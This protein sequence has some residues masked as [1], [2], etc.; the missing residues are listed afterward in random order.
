MLN[1]EIPEA[2]FIPVFYMG[3]EDADL[4]ELGQ[5]TIHGKKIKWDTHQTGA[6]GR[7]QIDDKL[8]RLIDEVEGQLSVEE[9]GPEII[10][11]LKTC[12]V[13][14]QTIEQATF[15]FVNALFK[16]FGLVVLLPDSASLKRLFQKTIKEELTELS[17]SKKVAETIAIFP[18]EYKVQAIGRD[19]NLFYL[20]KDLRARIEKTEN[21]FS[22]AGTNITF[23]H[24]A[25]LNEL[26]SYPERFS[27]NVI[28]RPLYQETIL[29][30][31]AFI[32]GG[33]E[34]A[35]W[36]ELKSTFEEA[37]ILFP[38]LL[39]R[40]SFMVID[41][42]TE[43]KLA[44]LN[45]NP[46]DFFQEQSKI[47][48]HF[49]TKRSSETLSLASEKEG[50]T[51]IYRQIANISSAVDPTLQK[52]V[53]ALSAQALNRLHLLEKKLLKVE[54]RKFETEEQQISKIK[55]ALFP[56][57]TL[58]ERV[59]NLLPY[60]ATYGK[61]FLKVIYDNSLGLNMQFCILKFHARLKG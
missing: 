18:S 30:N 56:G 8:L 31:I 59:D 11:L 37:G 2:Q 28:T 55:S 15:L 16:E 57:G 42:K 34:L 23:S 29:P 40:N 24:E 45:L 50:L 12:Y 6:V 58:Q 1:Q 36:L 48:A 25:I 9:Y 54:K 60:Y 13:K 20:K 49:V 53:Q 44:S 19:I 39:L 32:G 7:M 14:G 17:S 41:G 46:K 33:A 26:E 5:V 3:S 10:S 21:G 38:V 22:V 61:N 52:H 27:P 43:D 47:L 35:Y 4:E 51:E